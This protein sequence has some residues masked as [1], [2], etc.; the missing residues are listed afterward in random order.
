[1]DALYR[2]RE[3]FWEGYKK[4]TGKYFN[5]LFSAFYT[6]SGVRDAVI[7]DTDRY[8]E[9]LLEKVTRKAIV[10]RDENGNSIIQ[11]KQVYS[12]NLITEGSQAFKELTKEQQE[13]ITMFNDRVQEAMKLMDIEWQR[14][15]IP[16][17]PSS[18]RNQLYRAYK[19][20]VGSTVTH[21]QEAMRKMFTEFEASFSDTVKPENEFSAGSSNIF[22]SQANGAT[23]DN[24]EDLTGMSDEFVELEKHGKW[25]TNLE[26]V[27]DLAMMT[28]YRS[29]EMKTINDIL[30]A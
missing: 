17:V 21:Y 2:I 15:R 16:L 28:A 25:E 26:M 4:P 23:F 27:L 1:S 19:L 18:Y 6:L 13:F 5:A 22:H 29:D 11:E 30:L 12:Y 24:R 20:G 8:Y 10:G 9:P 3:K 14:G 7:S